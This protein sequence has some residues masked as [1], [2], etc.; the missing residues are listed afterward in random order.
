MNAL[1]TF[2]RTAKCSLGLSRHFALIGLFRPGYDFLL[3]ILYRSK[4][5][6]RTILGEEPVRVLPF[7]RSI[8]EE[9]E[10]QV[11]AALKS[12]TR[13]GDVVLDIGANIGLF[14][15]V[16]ARWVGK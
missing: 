1:E 16:M 2:I 9:A 7:Y 4:G 14:S 13:P 3:N 6:E 10:A 5:L 11:F 8:S 15:L 12:R